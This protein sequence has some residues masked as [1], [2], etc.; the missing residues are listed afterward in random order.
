MNRAPTHW[1]A[2]FGNVEPEFALIGAVILFALRDARRAP[3]NRHRAAARDD[4]RAYLAGP[5]FAA[6]CAW[7]NLDPDR[8]RRALGLPSAANPSPGES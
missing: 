4:A 3:T 8:A 5:A 1:R 2:F 6:D 7:L